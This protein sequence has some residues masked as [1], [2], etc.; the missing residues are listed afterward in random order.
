MTRRGLGRAW[1]L[2]DR[3][4][5]DCRL[6]TACLSE[7]VSLCFL[8]GGPLSVTAVSL[9]ELRRLWDRFGVTVRGRAG[10][11]GVRMRGLRG[12][13]GTERGVVRGGARGRGHSFG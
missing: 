1:G 9:W 5:I 2:V 3:R 4:A 10:S 13:P 12:P 7:V 11:G 8:L 6:L